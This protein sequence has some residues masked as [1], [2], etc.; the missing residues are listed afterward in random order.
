MTSFRLHME[1]NPANDTQRQYQD[2]VNDGI[3]SLLGQNVLTQHC[4]DTYNMVDNT[5][6]SFQR[7]EAPPG[8]S[9]DTPAM[10]PLEVGKFLVPWLSVCESPPGVLGVDMAT[11]LA[12]GEYQLVPLG[13]TPRYNKKRRK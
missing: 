9:V 11:V 8:T 12:L 3:S 10:L 2:A 1:T 13:I 7:G 5:M 4:G 6:W